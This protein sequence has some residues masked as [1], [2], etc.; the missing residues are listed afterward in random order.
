[1]K[2]IDKTNENMYI[3]IDDDEYLCVNAI[4]IYYQYNYLHPL[5][6]KALKIFNL[7]SDQYILAPDGLPVAMNKHI[8]IDYLN[9]YKYDN[10]EKTYLIKAVDLIFKYLVIKDANK[11]RDEYIKEINK[12]KTS[13]VLK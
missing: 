8:L 1:M 11:K 12:N 10:N 7:F 9:N 5:N 13:G 6:K 2:E 4:D 3:R